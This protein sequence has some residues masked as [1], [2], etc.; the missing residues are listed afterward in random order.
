MCV[1]VACCNWRNSE[2]AAEAADEALVACVKRT[3]QVAVAAGIAVMGPRPM[4]T[5]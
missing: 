5:V 1:A 3:N 4:I 2:G